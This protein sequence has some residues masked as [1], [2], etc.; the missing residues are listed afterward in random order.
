[1]NKLILLEKNMDYVEMKVGL[2]KDFVRIKW[3]KYMKVN[4]IILQDII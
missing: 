3:M 1:M 2:L 4:S